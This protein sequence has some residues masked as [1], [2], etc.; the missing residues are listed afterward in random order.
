MRPTLFPQSNRFYIV[1]Y[2]GCQLLSEAPNTKHQI[3]NKLPCLPAAGMKKIQNS[4][5]PH[6][7]PLLTGERGR[8]RG[9]H[10]DL[11]IVIYLGFVIWNL[12]SQTLL[13]SPYTESGSIRPRFG[14]Q[15]GAPGIFC[16]YG[17]NSRVIQ[18]RKVAPVIDQGIAHAKS[19]RSDVASTMHPVRIGGSGRWPPNM[20]MN[21][22]TV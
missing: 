14:P 5:P 16:C 8:V 19:C 12:G 20:D 22:G 4:S 1:L 7:L 18:G 13:G 2:K 3:T 15:T 17:P 10:L 9:G 6:P 21:V 11:K